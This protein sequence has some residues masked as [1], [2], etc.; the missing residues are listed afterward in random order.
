MGKFHGE[1]PIF[2]K[3]N[4]CS[5]IKWLVTLSSL[6]DFR[7]GF[8][9]YSIQQAKDISDLKAISM[10]LM[11]ANLSIT[12]GVYGILSDTTV[13]K[14]IA[15]LGSNPGGSPETEK[16][17]TQLEQLLAKL[18]TKNWAFHAQFSSKIFGLVDSK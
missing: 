10:N 4:N 11:H 17:I 13:Q 12:D 15:A 3:T 1:Y 14:E 2:P 16:I 9:V 18:K 8:T 7:H 5:S 6:H